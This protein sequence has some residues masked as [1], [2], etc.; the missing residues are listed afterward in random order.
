MGYDFNE[1]INR[2]GTGS[3][4]WD[5]GEKELPM[6]VADMD[7]RA[8]PEI[9]EALQ[10][11]LEHGIFGYSVLPDEW[12][13]AYIGWWERR[14]GFHMEREWLSFCTGGVPAISRNRGTQNDL[15]RLP[16]IRIRRI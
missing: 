3:L 4:K 7:F 16:P 1:A 2:R 11:R 9:L 12:Y 8:A 5:V 13:E 15:F 6:W 14:H 10:I